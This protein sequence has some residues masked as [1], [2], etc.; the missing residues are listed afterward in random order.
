VNCCSSLV[1]QWKVLLD[2]G[3]TFL[4]RFH[5]FVVFETIQNSGLAW[6]KRCLQQLNGKKGKN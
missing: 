6:C 5:P 2:K 1:N 3:V 4:G